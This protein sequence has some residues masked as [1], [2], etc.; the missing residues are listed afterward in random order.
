MSALC[1]FRVEAA[2]A[3]EQGDRTVEQYL[4]QRDN[5]SAWLSAWEVRQLQI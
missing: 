5:F 2:R 1:W 4:C 3:Q